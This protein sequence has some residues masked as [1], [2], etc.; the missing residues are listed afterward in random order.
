MKKSIKKSVRKPFKT[1]KT[2]T[3]IAS[4]KGFRLLYKL[5]NKFTT[6]RTADPTVYTFDCSATSVEHAEKQLAAS[7]TSTVKTNKGAV[8]M[9]KG[10]RVF[11][12]QDITEFADTFVNHRGQREKKGI[13]LKSKMPSHIKRHF[14]R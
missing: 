10:H 14:A 2:M 3:K 12:V 4:R 11:G 13:V 1:A 6:P 9:V 7:L 8:T 5:E